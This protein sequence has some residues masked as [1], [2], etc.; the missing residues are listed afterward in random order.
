MF[1]CR[2]FLRSGI[3]PSAI[4]ARISSQ[5]GAGGADAAAPDGPVAGFASAASRALSSELENQL[6][7]PHAPSSDANATTPAEVDNFLFNRL[8]R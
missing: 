5:S 6:V 3:K 8:F 2:T 7:A 1:E 4:F